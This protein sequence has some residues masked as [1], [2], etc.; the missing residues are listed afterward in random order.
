MG[1][2]AILMDALGQCKKVS[3]GLQMKPEMRRIVFTD[4]IDEG[5]TTGTLA[6]MLLKTATLLAQIQ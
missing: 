3:G 4:Y 1:E 5:E 6:I 2:E